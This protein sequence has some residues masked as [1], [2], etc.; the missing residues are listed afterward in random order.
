M[1]GLGTPSSS[2][3]A[4]GSGRI[5]QEPLAFMEVEPGQPR[6]GEPEGRPRGEGHRRGLTPQAAACY[7]PMAP[8]HRSSQIMGFGG[9]S[10]TMTTVPVTS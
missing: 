6:R 3:P 4:G 10:A 1:P 5:A 8:T 2:S 9:S 7:L